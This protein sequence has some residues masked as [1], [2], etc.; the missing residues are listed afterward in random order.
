MEKVQ[1]DIQHL[2]QT[3]GIR[4]PLSQE[5]YEAGQ[6][7]LSR[8]REIGLTDL[9]EQPFYSIR[10]I[11]ERLG[12]T[13]LVANFGILIGAIGSGKSRLLRLLGVTL[14]LVA[15]HNLR[16]ALMGRAPLGEW[17]WPQR[18]SHNIIARLPSQSNQAQ[19]RVVLLAHLDT[20]TARFSA[21]PP[22]R[23]YSPYLFSSLPALA[24][25]GALLT[26]LNAPVWLRRMVSA[27]MIGQAGLVMAD[28]IGSASPGAN[29]NAS[30][31]ALLLQL[32]EEL[33]QHPLADTEVVL[34]FT[35]CETAGCNG[36]AELAAKYGKEWASAWWLVIDS[37]GAGE[38]CWVTEHGWAADFGS[39]Y[40]SDP[41]L[42]CILE[43]V[44]AANPTLGIMGRPLM[45][46]NAVRP[47]VANGCKAAA[48]MGYERAGN[49]PTQWRQTGDTPAI[50]N[51]ATQQRAYEFIQ[52]I[53][54][55][56]DED[57]PKK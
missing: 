25:A 26:A 8:L 22:I 24:F 9:Q 48:V 47:L 45:T 55:K 18:R 33:T 17:F 56:I 57:T 51:P 40:H 36:A 11:G 46:V 13:T 3:I 1:A 10:R 49:T 29:D 30:G 20:D 27:L 7:V 53:L 35:G 28:E 23:P 6:Y 34:A 4:P 54:A 14:T 21:Q 44:A 16:R 38:L 39:R 19:A 5:E 52:A 2:A 15:H 37:V 42:M 50:L 43:Q 31:V 32:A 41:D 12:F